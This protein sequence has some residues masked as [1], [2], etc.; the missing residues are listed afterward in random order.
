MWPPLD[1]CQI[2]HSGAFHGGVTLHEPKHNPIYQLGYSRSWVL[3]GALFLT[4]APMFVSTAKLLRNSAGALRVHPG[5]R[6]RCG[7]RTST[8]FIAISRSRSAAGWYTRW[9]GRTGACVIA[10]HDM[11]VHEDDDCGTLPG[12]TRRG[13]WQRQ[14]KCC[15][16]LHNMCF[17]GGVR[18]RRTG[19]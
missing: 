7:M 9:F 6:G 13:G 15:C 18:Q 2:S 12:D 11:C 16:S 10:W 14:H 4:I 1:R 17:L 8:K 3:V 19:T 5:P